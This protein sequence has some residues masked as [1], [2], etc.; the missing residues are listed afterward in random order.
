MRHHCAEH[1]TTTTLQGAELEGGM[2]T[3]DLLQAREHG[4]GST[5]WVLRNQA[6]AL[7]QRCHGANRT[8]TNRDTPR[9]GIE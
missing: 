1:N 3:E 4:V 9:V 5:I 8:I 6:P 7:L 2:L